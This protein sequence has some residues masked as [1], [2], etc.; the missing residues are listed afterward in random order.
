MV[1]RRGLLLATTG[2]LLGIPLAYLIHRAVMSTLSLFDTDMGYDIA[3]MASALLVGVA[4]L[5][6]YLPARAAAR[7]E[8]T[9]VLSLE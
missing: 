4:I 6:S 9:Q 8:P 2:M 1:T 5:A 7:V 3:L